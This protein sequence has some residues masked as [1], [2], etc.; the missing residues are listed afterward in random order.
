MRDIRNRVSLYISHWESS[1]RRLPIGV[2]VKEVRKSKGRF[3][4]KWIQVYIWRES[5]L[6]S[7]WSPVA[8]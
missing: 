4:M 5:E 6:T 8:R 2:Q 1:L 7:N 3:V